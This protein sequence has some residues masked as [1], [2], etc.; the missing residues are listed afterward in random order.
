[1]IH[2]LILIT[3]TIWI[4][5][6]WLASISSI[7]FS[8]F[9]KAS[10]SFRTSTVIVTPIKFD[11][12]LT[13]IFHLVF[14]KCLNLVLVEIISW[15]LWI[16]VT[17]ALYW[18]DYI[19]AAHQYN[20]DKLIGQIFGFLSIIIFELFFFRTLASIITLWFLL[21]HLML[22]SIFLISFIYLVID[23]IWYSVFIIYVTRKP[24][25]LYLRL[26]IFLFNFLYLF[27]ICLYD[28]CVYIS[29]L[30]WILN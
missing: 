26:M 18:F 4:W 15:I 22:N 23:I 13:T 29:L 30:W 21:R 24:I 12:V 25:E 9:S 11:N 27:K 5:N 20:R 6:A 28:R 19:R 16:K 8:T 14:D 7:T 10:R 3:W 1:M 2:T 17:V